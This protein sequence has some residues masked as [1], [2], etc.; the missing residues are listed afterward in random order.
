MGYGQ[1]LEASVSQN[2]RTIDLRSRLKACR[3]DAATQ[4]P[5]PSPRFFLGKTGICTTGNLTT[6]AAQAKTGKSAF[7]GAAISAAICAE[8]NI[9]GRDTLGLSATPANG[10]RLLHFDTE[11]SPYDADRLV[12]RS[13]ERAGTHAGIAFLDSYRVAGLTPPNLRS[14]LQLLLTELSS[15]HGVFAVIIDGIAD[16]VCDVNCANECNAFIAELQ[17]LAIDHDCPIICILHENPTQE[18]GKMRGHLGSQLERKAESNLRLKRTEGITSVFGDKMRGAPILEK[19]GPAFGWSAIDDM[20]MST[21]PAGQ[22][23]MAK[24]HAKYADLAEDV[25]TSLNCTT[26]ARRCDVIKSI[27]AVRKITSSTA[28]DRFDEMRK[29]RVILKDPNTALWYRNPI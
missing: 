11:Q 26:Y 23:A 24:K 18:S 15:V 6:I 5:K 12:R 4:P 21:V 20:H 8:N 28:E 9:Q 29:L 16:F 14:A 27:M 2:V 7:I 3:F 13:L 10:M 1:A 19:D 17:Q 22:V 25:W